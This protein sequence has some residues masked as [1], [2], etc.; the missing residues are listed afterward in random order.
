MSRVLFLVNHDVVIYNFRLELVERL[1]R[2]GHKVVISSPYG[3]RINDLIKLGCEYHE[4]DISR[5]G[6][7][8]I[9][10][11]GLISTYKKLIKQ[12]KPDIVFTYTIKP[13]VYGGISCASQGVPCVANITGLGTAVV[14]GG[15]KHLITLCLYKIGLK[16]A[17]KVFFQNTENMQFFV[18]HKIAMGEYDLLPGSGV[19]LERYSYEE[20][21]ENNGK[22]IFL[23]VGRLMKDKGFREFVDA[24][25]CMKEK[26]ENISFEAVGFCEADF[27]NELKKMNAESYVSFLGQQR[28][29]HEYI[30]KA[31]AIILPSYHEGMSNSLLEA[32]ACGRPI[33]ASDIPGCRETFDE[34]ISGF[35]FQP[36]DVDSLCE[37]IEKFID[38]PYEK[39]AE[40]GRAGR[41][42]ME[43]EFDR[44]IVVDKYIN[45]VERI[46]KE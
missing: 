13:N 9:K 11:M 41:A 25:E 27:E 17:Q 23:F 44:N 38:L 24:A 37:A 21:P 35:G 26:K 7:N 5:H 8:P 22:E 40:M 14:N 4:I 45:E 36:R 46:S 39:K 32:A 43:K 1:L 18:K 28:D 20:Y 6:M 10:E 42:K 33:L 2:D 30:K 29:V 34:G 16:K 15:I 19:N 12:S 3:E 31:S